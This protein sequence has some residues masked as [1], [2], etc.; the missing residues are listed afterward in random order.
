[1]VRKAGSVD[2]GPSSWPAAFDHDCHRYF[3][4][5]HGFYTDLEQCI[6]SRR[7][8]ATSSENP[9]RVSRRQSYPNSI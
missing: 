8:I 9:V 1:M 4:L 6:P 2:L 7:H 5:G 3:V